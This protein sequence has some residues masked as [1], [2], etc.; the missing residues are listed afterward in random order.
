MQTVYLVIKEVSYSQDDTGRDYWHFEDMSNSKTIH[1]LHDCPK[2]AIKALGGLKGSVTKHHV[3]PDDPTSDVGCTT[4][5]SY[6]IQELC[7]GMDLK[8]LIKCGDPGE[9][10]NRGETADES[11]ILSSFFCRIHDTNQ[12]SGNAWLFI[13]DAA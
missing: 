6:W 8:E 4:T 9:Y 12:P 5:D 11:A 2:K 3:V 13:S 7:V 1:S 10:I